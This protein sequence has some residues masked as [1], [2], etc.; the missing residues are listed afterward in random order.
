[1]VLLKRKKEGIS[2]PDTLKREYNR[3]S[4]GIGEGTTGLW[5]L[6]LKFA[7]DTIY[8]SYKL[9]QLMISAGLARYVRNGEGIFFVICYYDITI[10]CEY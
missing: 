5:G 6:N 10:S 9:Q 8:I 2:E 7:G 1:M 3:N 4:R